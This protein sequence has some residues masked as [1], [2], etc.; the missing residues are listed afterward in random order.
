MANRETLVVD[1]SQELL[2]LAARQLTVWLAKCSRLVVLGNT[3]M[4]I[5]DDLRGHCQRS[6]QVW[7]A[8]RSQIAEMSRIQ[9]FG[10]ESISLI[11]T[12]VSY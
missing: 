8:V 9:R 5:E 11:I 12:Y 1:Y 2:A 3:Q 7:L 6:R 10:C 4:E